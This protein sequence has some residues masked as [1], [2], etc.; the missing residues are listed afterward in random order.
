[1]LNG[2][3]PQAVTVVPRAPDL[4]GLRPRL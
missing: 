1:V 4:R 3:M 2:Y